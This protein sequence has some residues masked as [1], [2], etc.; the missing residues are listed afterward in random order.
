VLLGHPVETRTIALFAMGFPL[1]AATLGLLRW[2]GILVQAPSS[3]APSSA[4]PVSTTFEP[5]KEAA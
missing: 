4:I 1:L 3:A 2:Q 5:L